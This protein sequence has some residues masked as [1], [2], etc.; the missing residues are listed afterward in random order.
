M[1]VPGALGP[2]P[3]D[4]YDRPGGEKHQRQS[5]GRVRP[6]STQ[7]VH[8]LT[9]GRLA[10]PLVVPAG[11]VSTLLGLAGPRPITPGRRIVA[12]SVI[13][14]GVGATAC[15]TGT[16]LALVG[17]AC[18]TFRRFDKAVKA[19]PQFFLRGIDTCLTRLRRVEHE[20]GTAHSLRQC[21]GR[22]LGVPTL[23]HA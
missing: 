6:R 3:Q 13:L 2:P 21:T 12:S 15:R 16:G 1:R 22:V 9:S 14:P 8:T 18:A 20:P 7:F 23:V 19:G 4:Q 11:A 10:G 5:Q 17:L